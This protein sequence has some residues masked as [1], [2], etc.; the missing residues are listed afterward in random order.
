MKAAPALICL[1][2]LPATAQVDLAPPRPPRPLPELRALMSDLLH[3]QKALQERFERY[4][5][6]VETTQKELDEG[7][8]VKKAEVELQ[9]VFHVGST[10]LRRTLLKN[11]QP[12]S[13]QESQAQEARIL[14]RLE[15]LQTTRQELKKRDRTIGLNLQDILA[16]CRITEYRR[17][18]HQGTEVLAL[19]FTPMP[20]FK[21]ANEGQELASKVS[22]RFLV[23]EAARQVVQAEARL[24]APMRLYL[25]LGATIAKDSWFTFEQRK[26][27]GDL[28][29]PSAMQ[30][31]FDGRF[32]V[33][34]KL[35]MELRQ[36]YRDYQRFEAEV[37]GSPVL[38]RS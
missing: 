5:Y 18:N 15:E 25:G 6:R 21:P 29:M 16:V 10:S 33:F 38:P 20:G 34:K 11:G 22:G 17:V 9:E 24:E 28:W 23:D 4:T 7:G 3:H 8:R 14:K 32:L 30:A 31:R 35:R 19:S 27:D 2:A 12:L 26:V 36:T 13:T 37:S 1:L